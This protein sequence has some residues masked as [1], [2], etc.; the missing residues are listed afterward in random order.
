[1]NRPTN[2]FVHVPP[3]PLPLF[4]HEFSTLPISPFNP[5][6]NDQCVAPTCM[7]WQVDAVDN[8]ENENKMKWQTYVTY[9]YVTV[10]YEYNKQLG[11]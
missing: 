1:M 2:N 8:C 3:S 4:F 6:Q 7:R 5:N 11:E 9:Y 10:L